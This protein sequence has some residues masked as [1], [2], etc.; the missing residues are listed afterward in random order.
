M[1]KRDPLHN[2]TVYLNVQELNDM[3]FALETS[4]NLMKTDPDVFERTRSL[5]DYVREVLKN[6]EG[7]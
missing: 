6:I 4:L 1:K 2:Y 5:L 7:L 3:R